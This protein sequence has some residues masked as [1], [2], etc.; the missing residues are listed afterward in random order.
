MTLGHIHIRNQ[1]LK[2]MKQEQSNK[3]YLQRRYNDFSQATS[4]IPPITDMTNEMK[5]IRQSKVTLNQ[6]LV[7]ATSSRK[8]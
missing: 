7:N 6:D 3:E 5:R 8:V 4:F 1:Y 2:K